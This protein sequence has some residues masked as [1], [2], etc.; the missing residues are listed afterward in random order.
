MSASR[1]EVVLDVFGGRATIAVTGRS[2]D[3]TAP[4]VAALAGAAT[5]RVIHRAL[6][7][8][9][10]GSEL[11]RLNADARTAVPASPLLRRL[12]W[13]VGEAGAATGGLVD[14][15][16]VTEIEGAGYFRSR[17][18]AERGDQLV[19]L[20]AA[21][22]AAVRPAL[23]DP[24]AHWAQVRVDEGRG[25]I[26]RP[27]GIRID[28]GGLVKG[29]ACDLVA[30][31]LSRHPRF[32]ISCSGDLRVGGTAARH[33]TIEVADPAGGDV[34]AARLRVERGAVATSGI[35]RSWW[36]TGDGV[37]HHLVDPGRGVPA[38]T[39]LLQATAVAPTALEAEVRAKA[40]FFAGADRAAEHLPDGGVI[41]DAGGHVRVVAAPDRDPALRV[42]L[43]PH[44]GQKSTRSSQSWVRR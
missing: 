14:A 2:S 12:A 11:S 43:F 19:L 40:A 44:S 16:L 10:A 34:P 27:A 22:A 25:T 15:T 7:R 30:A 41:V 9:D 33:R 24:A 29:M 42:D 13:A 28:G 6:T 31:S 1:H 17:V 5:L 8:F 37:A 4:Q 20:A 39:G 26:V 21:Q 38:W 32:A 3:G 18:G 23:A 35:G 36:E